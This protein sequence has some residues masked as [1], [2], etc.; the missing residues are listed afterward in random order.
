MR[1]QPC[2]EGT[3][4]P[5]PASDTVKDL[6]V[7]RVVEVTKNS[8]PAA[9]VGRNK[10]MCL[11][12]RPYRHMG[13]LGT[14]KLYDIRKN[15]FTFTPQVGGIAWAHSQLCVSWNWAGGFSTGRVLE[16]FSRVDEQP[17]NSPGSGVRQQS[18]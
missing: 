15:I 16:L 5:P 3:P 2:D 18:W 4:S 6:E 17:G 1:S 8:S 11:T 9:P 7:Q 10:Q 14:S 12:G 13:V